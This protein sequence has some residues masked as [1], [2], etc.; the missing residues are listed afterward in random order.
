MIRSVRRRSSH[1]R[2][3]YMHIVPGLGGKVSGGIDH[4]LSLRI[5]EYR[6]NHP[7]SP[8]HPDEAQ[9]RSALYRTYTGEGGLVGM[10]IPMHG[11]QRPTKKKTP[12]KV[13]GYGD[14]RRDTGEGLK[15]E[16]GASQASQS[17]EIELE[18]RGVGINSINDWQEN[19]ENG[20]CDLR[21]KRPVVDLQR[22]RSSARGMFPPGL[23][24]A[25]QD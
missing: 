16:K 19:S 13:V 7:A 18:K 1:I 20:A 15:S 3:T 9:C 11:Q 4:A 2:I 24:F 21:R 6:T 22:S 5:V 17:K 25:L 12:H 23:V 8:H 10:G 14:Q